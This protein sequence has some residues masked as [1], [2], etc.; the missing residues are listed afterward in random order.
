MVVTTDPNDPRL[1]HGSDDEPRPQQDAYL[2]LSEDER[3][4]GFMRPYRDAYYHF[5]CDTTL[6]GGPPLPPLTT[7]G[8]AIAETYAL[9]PKYYGS[10]YCCACRMHKPVVEFR[11]ADQETGDM[12]N[13]VVGS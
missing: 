7:M 6:T 5:M 3:A 2:V 12:T 9:N 4:K 10:T 8:R 11:W 13:E 1:G